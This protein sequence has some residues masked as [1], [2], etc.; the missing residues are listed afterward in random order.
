MDG[1][2]LPVLLG[3]TGHPRRRTASPSR[4]R[5]AARP[6]CWSTAGCH[7]RTAGGWGWSRDGSTSTTR[8]TGPAES[9]AGPGRSRTPRR[10]ASRMTRTGETAGPNRAGLPRYRT[11]TSDYHLCD[12]RRRVRPP[13]LPAEVTTCQERFCPWPVRPY[14]RPRP[15]SCRCPPRATP[16]PQRSVAQL[17][18]DLQRL[19]RQ[20][21]QATETYNATTEQLE[22]QRAEV[23]RLDGELARAR[24]ALKGSRTGRR[25]AGPAAVPEQRRPGPV[26]AAAPRARPAARTGRGPCHRRAGPRAGPYRHPAGHGGEAQ[27]RAGPCGPQGP[28][29]PARPGRPAAAAARRRPDET[30]RRGTPAG[31]SHPGPARRH[32]PPGTAGGHRG[33]AAAHHRGRPSRRRPGLAGGR[34]RGPLCDGPDRQA[35]PV[36]GEGAGRVRLLGPHLAGVVPG[37][38]AGPA[39]QPGAVGPTGEGPAEPAPAG[40]P[41]GVL[42]RG[43]ARGDVR[44]GRQGRPGAQT[45]RE[46]HRLPDRQLPHP[47]RGAPRHG[48][49]GA[50]PCRSDHAGIAGP[51]ACPPSTPVLPRLSAATRC[52]KGDDL[53]RPRSPRPGRRPSSRGRRRSPRSRRGR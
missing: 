35:V 11:D 39:H 6:P 49:A 46:G 5:R 42:P 2:V 38:D 10:P 22:R 53:V 48:G 26:R 34:P 9:S 31:R 25:A 50:R 7:A 20:A 12:G 4:T 44:G 18:T 15:P 41:G 33:P 21:E 19:Y 23:A 3:P 13:L 29:Y 40:R 43:H 32:R 27:G 1:R 28:R 45:G 16:D 36:G 8:T 37:G 30:R 17:P 24:L 47:R 52:H 14:W 51:S